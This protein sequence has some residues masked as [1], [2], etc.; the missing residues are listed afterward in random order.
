MAAGQEPIAALVLPG[1]DRPRAVLKGFVL[2]DPDGVVSATA[3]APSGRAYI[4]RAVPLPT[5]EFL[6]NMLPRDPA[7]STALR[8]VDRDTAATLFKA[9]LDE[10]RAAL[11]EAAAGPRPGR[12]PDPG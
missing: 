8:R 5:R 12:R 9:A 3:G 4:P 7:G 11:A 6:G 1:D 10:R 2:V